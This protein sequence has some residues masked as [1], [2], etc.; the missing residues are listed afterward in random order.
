[1]TSHANIPREY[2]YGECWYYCPFCG[3][4]DH[5]NDKTYVPEPNTVLCEGCGTIIGIDERKPHLKD[6]VYH[7][8]EVLKD[9]TNNGRVR[10]YPGDM[11]VYNRATA[12][13][14]MAVKINTTAVHTRDGVSEATPVI[15]WR[16]TY[17]QNLVR[18]KSRQSN[19]R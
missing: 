4:Y 12:N 1:M 8:M 3:F 14:D 16:Y 13:D 19:I 11:I 10:V 6:G 18:T 2:G 15:V 5:E 9:G 17:E 7:G